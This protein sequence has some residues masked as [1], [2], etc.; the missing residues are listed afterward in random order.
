MVAGIINKYFGTDNNR[1]FLK[2]IYTNNIRMVDER[3]IIEIVKPRIESF[4]IKGAKVKKEGLV[5]MKSHSKKM[6]RKKDNNTVIK[7]LDQEAFIL[8]NGAW[9][10]TILNKNFGT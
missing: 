8:A 7:R 3:L 9:N 1:C 10:S 5:I 4:S 2:M 6:Y